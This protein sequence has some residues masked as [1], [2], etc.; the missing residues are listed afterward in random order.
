LLFSCSND[1]FESEKVA[2]PP[3][4]DVWCLVKE[5]CVGPISKNLCEELGGTEKLGGI[6]NGCNSLSGSSSSSEDVISSSSLDDD[7]SSSSSVG[8]VS[9]S[10]SGGVVIPSSSSGV[11]DVS[12]SSDGVVIPSSSSDGDVSSSSSSEAVSSSSLAPPSFS[13][14][15]PFPSPYYVAKTKKEYIGDLVSLKGNTDGCGNITYAL[16]QQSNS[17]SIT[18]DTISFAGVSSSSSRTI[19]IRA[20]VQCGT[21]APLTKECSIDVVVADNFAKIETCHNPRVPVG[22]GKTTVEITCSDG[23]TPAQ[24][25]GCDCASPPNTNTDD[26]SAT[27]MFTVNGTKAQGSGCWATAPIPAAVV[28]GINRVLIEYTKEIK[29]VAY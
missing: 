19:N 9:S 6:E 18:G 20:S 11:I 4:K 14:C 10:S 26:W 5:K 25:I 3:K 21:G 1:G 27:N 13:E 28:V 23:N 29:C 22:P 16:T 24:T 2:A 7:V 8:S 17:I 12:S 15:S